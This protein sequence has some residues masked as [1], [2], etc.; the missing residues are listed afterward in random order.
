MF[1]RMNQGSG[2]VSPTLCGLASKKFLAANNCNMLGLLDWGDSLQL[3]LLA[4]SGS[5]VDDSRKKTAIILQAPHGDSCQRFICVVLECCSKD[6]QNFQGALVTVEWIIREHADAFVYVFTNIASLSSQRKSQRKLLLNGCRVLSLLMSR[7]KDIQLTKSQSD[8]LIHLLISSIMDLSNAR[9]SL[10]DIAAFDALISTLS[11][12]GV[13]DCF[14]RNAFASI[15]SWFQTCKPLISAVL[16]LL[17]DVSLPGD[18]RLVLSS[19]ELL[20]QQSHW[21]FSGDVQKFS[22]L[23]SENPTALL[24]AAGLLCSRKS[25]I[26]SHMLDVLFLINWEESALNL[27]GLIWNAIFRRLHWRCLFSSLS[28]QK[29]FSKL[30]G[31]KEQVRLQICAGHPSVYVISNLQ[32]SSAFSKRKPL[33]QICSPR[34]LLQVYCWR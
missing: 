6:H 10:L 24:L 1:V 31:L 4:D 25:H 21:S 26:P 11:L 13:I 7:H 12:R 17:A 15:A 19:L 34:T 16:S 33:R 9:A 5:N 23:K 2:G 20:Y 8:S 30:N 18:E 29:L 22:K 3:L 28:Q 14:V 27:Q 32:D